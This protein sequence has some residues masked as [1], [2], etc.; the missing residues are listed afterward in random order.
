MAWLG[1]WL[2]PDMWIRFNAMLAC[3]AL[4]CALLLALL[5]L[6]SLLDEA[7]S[8]LQLVAAA[9]P[10]RCL[11]SVPLGLERPAC[12]CST[13]ER[14]CSLICSCCSLKTFLSTALSQAPA[15]RGGLI[16]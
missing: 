6:R 16:S 4:G 2:A 13:V 8:V 5:L 9:F 15:L 3:R 11:L 1:E 14:W 10:L 12:R 7:A